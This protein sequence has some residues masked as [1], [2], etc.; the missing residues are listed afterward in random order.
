M[1][2]SRTRPDDV[3][4]RRA[5]LAWIVLAVAVSVKVVVQPNSHTVYP[6]F[7]SGASHWWADAPLYDDYD[8][9]GLDLFR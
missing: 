7:A 9:Q 6:V 4:L 3:W 1:D 8:E 5:L 2:G